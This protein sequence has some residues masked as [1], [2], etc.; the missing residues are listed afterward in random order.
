MQKLKVS[1]TILD[2]WNQKRF[3]EA[4]D[5]IKRVE[6]E[7]TVFMYEG[8]QLHQE[9]ATR[10]IKLFDFMGDRGVF[11]DKPN[12]INY[13]KDIDLNEWLRISLV[14]DYIEGSFIADW[15][16]GEGKKMQLYLYAYLYQ[17]ITGKTIDRMYFGHVYRDSNGQI[18]GNGYS[19]FKN[20]KEKME[21]AQDFLYGTASEIYADSKVQEVILNLK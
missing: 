16:S 1:W 14:I 15:K 12:G 19:L 13:Y 5:V 11:E 2:L 17:E 18:K 8:N 20:T 6:N 4:I 10:R 3:D 9:I 7:P 21:E